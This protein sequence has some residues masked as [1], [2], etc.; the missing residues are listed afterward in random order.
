MVRHFENR[1][2]EGPG[3]EVAIN[4]AFACAHTIYASRKALGSLSNDDDDAED[5]EMYKDF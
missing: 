1:R 5:D 3:D 2:G 4:Q